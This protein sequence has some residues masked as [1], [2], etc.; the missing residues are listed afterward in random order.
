[1]GTEIQELVRDAE[2]QSQET[3]LGSQHRGGHLLYY[4][5]ASIFIQPLDQ[6]RLDTSS[7]AANYP[8]GTMGRCQ[9]VSM[10]GDFSKDREAIT[11]LFQ[12]HSEVLLEC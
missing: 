5:V 2:S 10:Q 4:T 7:G 8:T 11:V 1:M 12:A 9:A 3:G 6:W